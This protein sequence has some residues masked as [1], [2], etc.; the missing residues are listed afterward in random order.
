M[1]MKKAIRILLPEWLF[2]AF[3]NL[4]KKGY[5]SFIPDKFSVI[6]FLTNVSSGG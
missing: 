5:L 1:R 2:Y 4:S 6:Y 3:I